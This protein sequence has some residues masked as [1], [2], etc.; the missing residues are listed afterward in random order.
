MNEELRKEIAALLLA[1]AKSR[2]DPHE[3]EILMEAKS[4]VE[5]GDSID[6]IVGDLPHLRYARGLID[7]LGWA[8]EFEYARDEAWRR[9]A[10]EECTKSA[11]Y[12]R[13]TL[14]P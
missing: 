12:Y 2:V 3:K 9:E 6:R 14:H 8:A 7:A 5:Q 1:A 4:R 13:K 11:N 10:R